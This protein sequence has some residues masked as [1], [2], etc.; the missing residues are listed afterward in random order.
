MVDD[1]NL[2]PVVLNKRKLTYELGKLLYPRSSNMAQCQSVRGQYPIP[3]QIPKIN[4]DAPVS[5]KRMRLI[6]KVFLHAH[7]NRFTRI[8]PI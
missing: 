3:Y 6:L 1:S 4:Q 2:I 5:S 8:I 7:P